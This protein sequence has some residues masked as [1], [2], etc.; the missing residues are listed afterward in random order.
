[1]R[2][3]LHLQLYGLSK[4]VFHWPATQSLLT[5]DNMTST[6]QQMPS[7]AHTS[8]RTTACTD[9]EAAPPPADPSPVSAILEEIH[10]N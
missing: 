3:E 8:Q 5:G 9:P 2:P 7:P 4:S 10:A 1:M 6:L